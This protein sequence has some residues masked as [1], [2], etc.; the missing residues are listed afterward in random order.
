[1]QQNLV[2]KRTS[3]V[4]REVNLT[5]QQQNELRERATR[6]ESEIQQE[7]KILRYKKY[8]LELAEMIGEKRTSDALGEP[9]VVDIPSTSNSGS[10]LSRRSN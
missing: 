9:F 10:R 4:S 6:V 1:M 8:R 7:I 2:Q 5:P 3:I